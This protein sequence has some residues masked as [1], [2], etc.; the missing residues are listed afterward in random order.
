MLDRRIIAAACGLA[1]VAAGLLQPLPASAAPSNVTLSWTAETHKRIRVT[2]T[3][4]GEPNV[5]RVEAPGGEHITVGMTGT[6][7]A[8]EVV[9]EPYTVKF[10]GDQSLRISVYP[11]GSDGEPSG[12]GASSA[13]FD[14]LQPPTIALDSATAGAGGTV[15]LTWH[16]GTAVT[17][18]NPGDPLDAPG[19]TQ[20]F[21]KTSRDAV[22]V[23]AVQTTNTSGGEIPY[24]Q[25]PYSAFVMAENEWGNHDLDS[26]DVGNYSVSTGI[27]PIAT[28]GNPL[29]VW[30]TV[31]FQWCRSFTAHPG[32]CDL[33]VDAAPAI[34]VY[35]QQRA[36]ATQPWTTVKYAV[37]DDYGRF[38]FRP[39]AYGQQFRV[40][41]PNGP[42]DL[43]RFGV[44]FGTTSAPLATP[45]RYSVWRARFYDDTVGYG[46]HATALVGVYPA[47]DVRATLQ[48]WDGTTWVAAKWVY[49]V[50]GRGSYT[51]TA[52]RR[53]TTAYRFY[54]PSIT[55]DG[56]PIT[57][58]ITPTFRL[59]VS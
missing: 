1:V 27:S 52:L 29:S 3:D 55:Y 39:N 38:L 40:L 56:K 23:P 21:V 30:G 43:A 54:L 59:T 48:R 35:L 50:D 24:V 25:R 49:L 51:F 13:P 7:A 6:S 9:L 16:L 57:A 22:D 10:A 19:P 45:T 2:W 15:K 26:V 14:T 58:T 28:Y 44:G 8:N 11:M 33:S 18:P 41:V 20:I 5:V 17:D 47:A 53:G 31:R 42:N 37:T 12:P 4:A 36:D 34:Q 32:S 46:Q